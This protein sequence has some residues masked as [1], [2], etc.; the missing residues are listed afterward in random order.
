MGNEKEKRTVLVVDDEPFIRLYAC[1]V[2]EVAGYSTMEAGDAAEAMRMLADG[3]ISVVI[4]DIEMPGSMDGLALAHRV[5]ATW[6]SIAVIVA[7]GHRLPLPHE[8]PEESEFLSKPFSATAQR[9]W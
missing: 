3:R 7:S 4:T 5:R 6:P 9:C 2:M 8:L 1:G